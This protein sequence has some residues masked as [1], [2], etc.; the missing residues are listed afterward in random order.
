MSHGCDLLST[1]EYWNG[2]LL[3]TVLIIC[4]KL[5]AFVN[6][7]STCMVSL[8]PSLSWKKLRSLY[9]SNIFLASN[10][11]CILLFDIC[12]GPISKNCCS[13]TWNGNTIF[14]KTRRHGWCKLKVYNWQCAVST[15]AKWM[16][17]LNILYH[18]RSTFLCHSFCFM[19]IFLV[20]YIIIWKD[21][22]IYK[23]SG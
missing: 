15:S 22:R 8:S 4:F 17:L 21:E 20:F 2:L 7:V 23:R 12:T 1:F 11:P 16:C 6:F 3:T 18:V 14:C 13:I 19:Q 9:G 10:L 5:L